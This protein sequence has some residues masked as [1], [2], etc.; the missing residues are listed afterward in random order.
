MRSPCL[1]AT[2][3]NAPACMLQWPTYHR[4]GLMPFTVRMDSPLSRCS[5]ELVRREN[6]GQKSLAHMAYP[7]SDDVS[8]SIALRGA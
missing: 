1:S 4:H 3:C 6:D 2:A 5:P 7:L 8:R